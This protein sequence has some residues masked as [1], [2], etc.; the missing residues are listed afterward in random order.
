MSVYM[1]GYGDDSETT[2]GDNSGCAS[3]TG[4]CEC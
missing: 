4:V 2:P 3:M 1:N